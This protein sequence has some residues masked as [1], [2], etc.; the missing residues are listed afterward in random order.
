[1]SR[2]Y[3]CRQCCAILSERQIDQRCESGRVL[4]VLCKKGHK[5]SL[6]PLVPYPCP[7]CGEVSKNFAGE[8]RAWREAGTLCAGCMN[9]LK[10]LREFEKD[11]ADSVKSGKPYTC[12]SRYSMYP[13]GLERESYGGEDPRDALCKAIGNVAVQLGAETP[14]TSNWGIPHLGGKHISDG[15]QHEGPVRIITERL[16]DSWNE[17][18]DVINHCVTTAY[19]SGVKHGQSLLVQLASGALTNDDFE[20]ETGCDAC[21]R[22]GAE[23][24]CPCCYGKLFHSSCYSEH[25][26]R[27]H[28][29]AYAAIS[30]GK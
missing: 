19:K 25:M 24:K 21:G 5:V 26:E 6:V 30:S 2:S 9:E 13:V 27:E 14:E 1:M 15:W 17:L 11:V 20:S 7:G 8:P 18:L 29:K 10:R 28:P 3:W 12:S 4:Y 23:K 16:A 22:P